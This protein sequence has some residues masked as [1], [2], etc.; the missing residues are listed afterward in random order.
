M[1]AHLLVGACAALVFATAVAAQ[2]HAQDLAPRNSRHALLIGIDQYRDPG[3]PRLAG[4]AHD[5]ASAQRMAEAMAIPPQNIVRILD[6]DATAARIGA[7]FEAL[8]RRARDGDRVFVYYSGHG[9]RWYDTTAGRE[10]CTEGLLA[11]DSEV[12]PNLRLAEML[13][14]LARKTDKLF[15]FYDAC[16]S[17]GV[18][19]APFR[20]PPLQRSLA[21]LTPKF[22]AVGA[23]QACTTPSNFRTRSLALVMQDRGSVPDNV[24]HVAASRP[25]EVSF[26]SSLTGGLATSAWRDCFL[27]DARDLDRSGAVTVTEVTQCAQEKLNQSIAS[28]NM[29]GVLGQNLTV[30]GNTSFVPAWIASTFTATGAPADESPV[31]GSDATTPADILAEVHRQRDAS[32]TVNVSLA[33]P[34]LRIDHD[35]LEMTIRSNRSGYVYV[36]I[37]GSDRTSLYLLFPNERD[38]QNRL[39]AGEP[40]ALPR[41]SWEVAA[42]GPAGRDTVLVMVT[43]TPRQ[44]D[45]LHAQAD[46]P[47]MKAL[48]DDSGRSRLQS[49]LANGNPSSRCAAAG[50][51]DAAKDDGMSCS[52]AFGAAIVSVEEVW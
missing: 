29:P 45:L 19:E 43:D 3:I 32:R 14:P 13:A 12:L 52:D 10:G 36:A 47:F 18:A 9:T 31:A 16:F 2:A 17:G 37:A 25:D 50:T 28:I 6:R 24:V 34:T 8:N 41:S 42:S 49:V 11:A 21:V 40:L 26:D 5:M 20:M 33:K 4:V 27:G 23:S 30:A 35:A 48:L 44:L 7:E 39:A 46:G 38:R 1:N 51:R 15:V 22:A